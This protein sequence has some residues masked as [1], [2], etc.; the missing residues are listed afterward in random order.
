MSDAESID[1]A[2]AAFVDDLAESL[3]HGIVERDRFLTA[4]THPSVKGESWAGSGTYERLE[5][6]GDRVFGLIVAD[7]LFD[8]FPDEP[9]GAL[10]KRFTALVRRDALA[11]VALEIGLDRAVMLAKGERE[12]GEE[13]NPTILA[14]V[15][16]ALI[17]ALY[18]DGGLSL[19][20]RFVAAHWTPR[21]EADPKPPED[22]KTAL[23]EWAQGRGLKLP[24]Y[25]EV[26]REGPAHQPTFSVEVSVEGFAPAGGQ[27]RSKRFAEQVAA[28]RLLSRIQ[29]EVS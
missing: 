22:P 18:R 5:F 26:S 24:V 13:R 27:G 7:L 16:E 21:L 6:L 1:A 2:A 19:A 28:G 29:G 20:R 17:A 23:Q 9:E 3:G 11:E 12:S 14:D 15:C 25:R 4:L 8:R 10:A